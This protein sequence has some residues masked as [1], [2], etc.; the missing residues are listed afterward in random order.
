MTGTFDHPSKN[1]LYALIVAI[2]ISV[3]GMMALFFATPWGIGISPDSVAYIAAA[4]NLLL[5]NGFTATDGVTP[6]THFPPFYSWTLALFGFWGDVLSG[7]RWLHAILFG[8]NSLL[9]AWS[10]RRFKPRLALSIPLASLLTIVSVPMMTIHLMAWTESLFLTLA[11]TGF[12]ALARYL[13]TYKRRWLIGAALFI[14]FGLLTRYA[15]MALVLT[16]MATIILF[17]KP[18]TRKITDFLVFSV[19][20]LF[21]M[22]L[23]LIRNSLV[24]GTATSR[25]I[26]FHPIGKSHLWQAFYTLSN[27]IGIPDNA[28]NILRMGA[29]AV[30]IAVF[31]YVF[32]AVNHTIRIPKN[33]SDFVERTPPIIRIMLTFLVIY[34]VFLVI[35]I[36]FLD[37]NTPLDNRILSPAYAAGLIVLLYVIDRSID[38]LQW[39]VGTAMIVAMIVL[40]MIT[41]TLKS[42][43]ILSESYRVGMG[44][45]NQRWQQSSLWSEIRTFSS[46]TIIYSN[47]PEVVYIY[48]DRPTLHIPKEFLKTQGIANPNYALELAQMNDELTTGGGILVYFDQ[49][50]GRTSTKEDIQSLTL[51]AVFEDAEG[52]ILVGGSVSQ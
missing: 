17:A 31:G 49:L 11:L 14:G 8:I 13:Q 15:G 32:W 19:I 5:S 22:L 37:A 36:S 20:S 43:Q 34:A 39:S 38:V 45:S 46:N 6:L 52:S 7:A 26:A 9:M 23:W 51:K 28:S 10:V 21:P 4:R 33:I 44:F 35:S 24:A 30:I 50:S 29:W 27:W 18:L 42:S 12:L 2:A 48:T 1:N 47:V 40:L 41:S 3:G 16:A 25:S